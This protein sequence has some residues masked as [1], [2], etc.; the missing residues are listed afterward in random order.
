MGCLFALL[1]ALSSFTVVLMPRSNLSH[2][3]QE[4]FFVVGEE[5]QKRRDVVRVSYCSPCVRTF[6]VD[7]AHV[8]ICTRLPP[9]G[10]GEMQPAF[11]FLPK[12][13]R[14]AFVR[15]EGAGCSDGEGSPVGCSPALNCH[16][17]CSAPIKR[18]K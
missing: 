2:G 6:G 7:A 3:L 12:S 1:R 5:K 8:G 16:I 13:F 10:R 11:L 17:H 14:A 4:P 18:G 15:R 9:I